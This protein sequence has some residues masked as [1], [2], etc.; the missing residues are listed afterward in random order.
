M[1]ESYVFNENKPN[2]I[3][4]VFDAVGK[5]DGI[6]LNKE[7]LTG[8]D[9]LNN[10]DGVLLRFKNHKIAIAADIEAMY[11]QVRVSKSDANALRFFLQDYLTQDVQEIH[12]IFVRIFV[13][14]DSPNCE[15]YALK[16]R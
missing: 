2:K 11:Y 13:G 7:L 9:L 3:R 6:S 16:K 12:K 10:L 8:P 5:H 15:N 1:Q 4:T 14:K